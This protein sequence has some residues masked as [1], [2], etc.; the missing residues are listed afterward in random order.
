MV[1]YCCVGHD[2]ADLCYLY[3]QRAVGTAWELVTFVSP[4]LLM[5]NYK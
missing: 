2:R 4:V 5:E 3:A 1:P